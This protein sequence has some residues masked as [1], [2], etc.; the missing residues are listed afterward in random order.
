MKDGIGKDDTRGDHPRLANQ[1]YSLYARAQETRNLAAI[2][3]AEELSERDR[4]YLKFADAFD[5]RFVAQGED[6]NRS[7][8]ETL[9]LA[10]DLLGMFTPD[11]LNRV[12]EADISKYYPAAPAA[13]V[14]AAESAGR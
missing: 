12:T 3:G 9:N 4:R 10:W 1:L 8:V 11:A 13:S 7:I 14:A 5:H 6:E 2:V